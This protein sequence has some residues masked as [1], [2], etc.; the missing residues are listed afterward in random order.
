MA[1]KSFEKCGENRS[2]W[3]NT[4]RGGG[5]SL[6][7]HDD[8]VNPNERST[9]TVNKTPPKVKGRTAS[10]T[11]ANDNRKLYYSCWC[12]FYHGCET[13]RLR[14]HESSFSSVRE[15]LSGGD[16]LRAQSKSRSKTCQLKKV[17]PW[18]SSVSSRCWK[19]H[20]LT[21]LKRIS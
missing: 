18:S 20:F 5:G 11:I 9:S 13:V 8:G 21:P 14:H 2:F 10:K 4:K 12:N 17:Y 6:E 1:Q 16:I 19:R 15:T 7:P 3:K